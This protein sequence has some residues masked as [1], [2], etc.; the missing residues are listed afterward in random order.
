M[1]TPPAY[2][3]TSD[4][5]ANMFDETILL[6]DLV[7]KLAELMANEVDPN[8]T[9]PYLAQDIKSELDSDPTFYDDLSET[10]FDEGDQQAP[11][12]AAGKVIAATADSMG[13]VVDEAVSKKITDI[14]RAMQQAAKAAN[15]NFPP[16]FQAAFDGAD[17]LVKSFARTMTALSITA[18]INS[19]ISSDF[20]PTEIFKQ[21]VAGFGAA[22]VGILAVPAVIA[23]IAAA[24]VTLPAW[25][26]VLIAG[27]AVGLAAD[28]I[29]DAITG[30]VKLAADTAIDIG[31]AVAN[32]VSTALEEMQDFIQQAGEILGDVL[33][34]LQAMGAD[35]VSDLEQRISDLVAAGEGFLEA[36]S[37][38]LQEAYNDG[39]DLL[40]DLLDAAVVAGQLT[41]EMAE[42]ILEEVSKAFD[43]ALDI[44]VQIAMDAYDAVLQ[45]GG[46]AAEA[47][48]QLAASLADSLEEFWDIGSQI[49]DDFGNT[50]VDFAAVA[51]DAVDAALDALNGFLDNAAD[52]IGQSL[53][54]L[55]DWFVAF[56]E[57]TGDA[58]WMGSPLV[59]D[60]DADGIELVSLENSLLHWDIDEDGFAEHTGWVA[61]D[62]GMLAIDLNSDGM[63][64]DHTELFGSITEDGFTAL[65]VYDTNTDGVIDASDS[66]FGDLLVWQDVNQN[67]ISEASELYTLADLDIVSIDLNA[68]TPY[69]LYIEGHNISHVSSY[70][71]DDGVS[72][73]QTLEIV[74]AWFQYDNRNTEFSGDYTL[75]LESLFVTTVRGYGSLPDLHISASI[76]NDTTDPGS[77]M[78]LLQD[79]ASNSLEELFVGDRSV[80]DQ[81]REIM[82]RWA[83]ADTVDPTSMGQW[84]DAQELT[85]INALRGEQWL[86]FGNAPNPWSASSQGLQKA[87]EIAHYAITAKLIAQAAG[88]EL[89]NDDV[90]YNPASD[91]F[92]GFTA[93][94]QDALDDLIAKSLDGTQVEN[95]TEY[96]A[97][98]VNVVDNSVGISNLDTTQYNVLEVAIQDSD[99]TLTIVD[100]QDKI[101]KNIE[102]QL[103]WTP[104]GDYILGTSAIDIYDGTVGDDFYSGAAGE[105]ILNGGLGNDQLRGDADNDRLDGQLGDD[106]LWGGHGDDTYKFFLG[107]GDDYIK[108]TSGS[109]TILFGAGI[110]ANDV[111][112]VRVGYY[113]LVIQIDP[114]V[115]YGSIHIESQMSGALIETLEFDDGSTLDMTILDHTYIGTEGNDTIYGVRTGFGGSGVDTIYGEG[116]DDVIYGYGP[117]GGAS[118]TVQNTI[119]GG[120]G[121]DTLFAENGGDYLN[122]EAGDDDIRGHVG[123]DII[124]G[125]LGN[126]ILDGSRGDDI[127]LK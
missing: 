101:A 108:D 72:G 119:Y 93:F 3:V 42:V 85:F 77:L 90:F 89:F 78:S 40:S 82:L 38:A 127:Y 117:T 75:D 59:L 1:S 99:D 4:D 58:A 67:A 50:A 114:N 66:Q 48:A 20:S 118:A 73:P 16:I 25:G 12:D 39:R 17:D 62:D 32:A 123:N 19:I 57:A 105:D 61:A 26:P 60:L 87:F 80:M 74:D 43:I 70:T 88:A 121:N 120:D 68:S 52:A 36:A 116:G 124:I 102:D 98:V 71:V 104:D 97:Q 96:W 37:Q 103:S 44:A 45:A 92:E 54:D 30:A 34:D 22:A 112:F 46:T 65:S 76:D 51:A 31:V 79:F 15:D 95:K 18:A 2:D 13:D 107:H 28:T 9:N 94:N 41:V 8:N 56:W 69:E 122:G 14:M 64:T 11:V 84:A 109:D 111:S 63:V 125:G 126:D 53:E 24:G 55:G 29:A 6:D 81:S 106:I 91:T 10:V 49:L 21:Y 100:L 35:L 23:A 115:G 27:V 86:L 113:D 5:I 110:T 47:L 7:Q 83:S 33:A